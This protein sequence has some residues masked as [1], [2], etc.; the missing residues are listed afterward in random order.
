MVCG[1]L[2]VVR[3]L[4]TIVRWLDQLWIGLGFGHLT[5]PAFIGEGPHD[6][7]LTSLYWAAPSLPEKKIK[8]AFLHCSENWPYGGITNKEFAIA[9]KHL[10]VI[11]GYSHRVET[12]GDVVQRR[13]A[14]CVVLLHGHYAALLNGRLAGKDAIF[15]WPSSSVVYCYWIL[16]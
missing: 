3:L 7:A 12:L 15:T 4:A 11:H 6:C 9:L 1:T 10:G 14:R 16:R 5:S 2:A 13:H 8:E